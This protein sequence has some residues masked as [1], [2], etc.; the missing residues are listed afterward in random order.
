MCSLS[1]RRPGGPARRS[2]GLQP[3]APSSYAELGFIVIS[4][5]ARGTTYRSADFSQARYGELNLIGLDDH[6]A[7][8][9]ALA[10]TRPYLDTNRVGIVGHSYGGFAALR[11]MLEFPDFYKVGI[12]SAAMVDTQGMYADYHWSA[13]HGSPRYSDGTQWRPRP[14]EVPA[15]WARLNAAS[16]AGNLRGKL[17]IQ[18]GALDENV[19]PG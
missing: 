18:M 7:A 4:V 6:I 17:L 14:D 1:I 11:G 16:L 9:T 15:N 12:S 8:I 10:R 5:D 19:P 13:F 3:L 2:R